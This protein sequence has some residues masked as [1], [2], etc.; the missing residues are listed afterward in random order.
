LTG[1]RSLTG[2]RC[3]TG[4]GG[5]TSAGS[6]TGAGRLT[7]ILIAHSWTQLRIKQDLLQRPGFCI[8]TDREIPLVIGPDANAFC[9]L[10]LRGGDPAPFLSGNRLSPVPWTM[11][12]VGRASS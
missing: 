4:T 6:L 5:L 9:E 7:G 10:A 8:K 1:A 3:L 2:A 11:Y 12:N